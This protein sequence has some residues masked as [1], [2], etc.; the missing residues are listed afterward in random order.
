MSRALKRWLFAVGGTAT[1]LLLL[2]VV[3]CPL[4]D[5]AGCKPRLERVASN[6]L[7]LDVRIGGRLGVGLLPGLHVTVE[8]ARILNEQ[9]V[10][11]ASAKR[12]GLWIGLFPL[13]RR[14]FRVRRIELTEPMLSLERDARGRFNLERL[15]Q[16]AALC[17]ALDG[18]SV[19]LTNGTLRYVDRRSGEEL[20]ATGIALHLSRVRFREAKGAELLK[21]ASLQAE[22]A[23]GEIRRKGVSM[24]AVRVAINGK[25]GV[26]ELDPVTMRVFGGQFAGGIHADCSGPVP[27]FQVRCSLARFRIEEFVKTLSPEES[28]QGQM[29]FS[30]SLSMQGRTMSEIVKTAAGDVSLRGENLILEGSDLD[31]RLARFESSQNFNLVDVGAVLLA[32]PLGLAVTKGYSFTSLLR[33]SGGSSRIR[34]LVSDWRVDRGVASAKDVALATSKN[35]IA[36]QGELDFVRGSFANVTVAM[37]NAEGCARVRQAVRGPFGKPVVEKPRVLASLAGPVVKLYQRTRSLFPA[38]P[39]EAFYSGSVAAP[40]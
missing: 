25:G 23:C 35:R 22:L 10:A 18:A 1:M 3:V 36:L 34:T 39:C 2:A 26:F 33:G 8:D 16:A 24:S 9:K 4:V 28:A 15:R 40:E 5:F 12:V 14:E 20:E 11:I 17:G 29:D 27:A 13:L 31:R 21:S 37:I 30:A 6:A 32:G 7:G 38:G 19:E